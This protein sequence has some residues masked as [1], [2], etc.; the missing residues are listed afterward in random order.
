MSRSEGPR[1]KKTISISGDLTLETVGE[2]REKLLGALSGGDFILDLDAL[3]RIDIVGL[4]LLYALE[5]SVH[6]TGGSVRVD[7]GESTAR[8]SKMITF[9]GLRPLALLEQSGER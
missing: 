7:G 6:E 1:D 3:G 2:V 5:R 4:Q 9:A 8:L